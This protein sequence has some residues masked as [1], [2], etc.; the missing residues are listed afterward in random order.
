ME[1]YIQAVNTT[2]RTSCATSFRY[3]LILRDV[4]KQ[5][6]VMRKLHPSLAKKIICLMFCISTV[7]VLFYYSAM[8]LPKIVPLFSDLQTDVA[9]IH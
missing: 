3:R 1:S 4:Y 5:I 6:R 2:S 9:V 8:L 7:Q